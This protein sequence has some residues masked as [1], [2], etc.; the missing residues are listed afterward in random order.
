MLEERAECERRAEWEEESARGGKGVR[1]MRAAASKGGSEIQS[2]RA[3][4][5]QSDDRNLGVREATPHRW[6]RGRTE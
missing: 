4:Q 2:D 1:R 6:G 5:G 3:E